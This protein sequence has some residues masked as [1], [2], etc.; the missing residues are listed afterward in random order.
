MKELM[1]GPALV[2]GPEEGESHWQPAPHCGY[3]T[4]KVGPH[5]HPSNHFSM[6][7]QVIPPG[8]HIRAHGHARNDEI[9]FIYEGKGHCVVDGAT[10]PLE[11]GSTLALG[12]FVEHSIHNDGAGEMRLAWFFTPPGLEQV[13]AASGP[14]RTPGEPAPADFDRPA[15][16]PRVLERAGWAT[17][18][19]LKAA[20]RKG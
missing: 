9:L 17:P 5:N 16:L 3:M 1:K 11:P 20:R 2:I 7:I 6:G 12:R 18:E 14:R 10:H 4:V 15:D 13:V 8:C 19:Q